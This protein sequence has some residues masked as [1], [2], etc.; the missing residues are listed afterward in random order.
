MPPRVERVSLICAA[1]N[2]RFDVLPC[3][4]R[5]RRFCSLV[6]SVRSSNAARAAGEWRACSGCGTPIYAYPN[7]NGQ[8]RRR[9]RECKAC[10]LTQ[11][12]G[13]SSKGVPK[14][15]ETRAKLSAN[16]TNRPRGDH[17]PGWKGGNV[18]KICAQCG[19]AFEVSSSRAHKDRIRFCGTPCWYEWCRED[20]TR[21]P[22]WRGGYEP[23]YGPNWPRQARDARRRDAFTCQ[24]CGTTK[25][26]WTLEVH[27]IRAFR[28]FD[29]DW[30]SAN[31]LTN[32]VTLCKSCHAKDSGEAANFAFRLSFE[33]IA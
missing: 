20:P 31:R 6:C 23:Y 19:T 2:A 28:T 27:H 10:Y 21:H 33:H 24:A 30:K 7:K 25:S 3:D 22:T 4:A 12:I 26:K 14:S 9:Y 18:G 32:L 15:A 5:K 16:R 17:H 29:G 1:C 13:R 11:T 8:A